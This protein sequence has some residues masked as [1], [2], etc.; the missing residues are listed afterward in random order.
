MKDIIIKYKLVPLKWIPF[1]MDE[2][3][4]IN[5]NEVNEYLHSICPAGYFLKDVEQIKNHT[6][7]VEMK[8]IYQK[9]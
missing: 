7:H 2:N 6:Y 9:M 8:F 5:N 1:I 4:E 3:D